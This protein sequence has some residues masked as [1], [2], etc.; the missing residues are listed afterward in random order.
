MRAQ[1]EKKGGHRCGSGHK[2][3]SLPR[4]IPI[5][6]IYES[7]PP[8]PPGYKRSMFIDY[9]DF[10]SG[11]PGDSVYQDI[12]DDMVSHRSITTYL[13]RTST[14]TKLWPETR[15]LLDD[16]YRPFNVKLAELL[17]DERFMFD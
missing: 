4:H 12:D 6:D 5:L 14:Y 8:P 17:G 15:K 2:W 7:A 10:T 16:F 1:L 11:Y 13:N 9:F 3:G